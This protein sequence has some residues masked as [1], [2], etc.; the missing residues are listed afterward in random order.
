MGK[1]ELNWGGLSTGQA[2]D[3]CVITTAKERRNLFCGE[4]D[5]GEQTVAVARIAKSTND[6]GAQSTDASER[7]V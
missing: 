4:E 3:P 2:L 6:S 7:P 5:L 1:G